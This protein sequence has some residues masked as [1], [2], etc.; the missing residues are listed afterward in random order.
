MKAITFIQNLKQTLLEIETNNSEHIFYVQLDYELVSRV[1]KYAFDKLS[2]IQHETSS[3]EDFIYD[4]M[5]RNIFNSRIRYCIVKLKEFSIDEDEYF[6][7]I[8]QAID[9]FIENRD[10]HFNNSK[11]SIKDRLLMEISNCFH[12]WY[13]P[14]DVFLIQFSQEHQLI[15]VN[16]KQKN[17]QTSN[18]GRFFIELPYFEAISF[19][20]ALEIVLTLE[21]HKNAFLSKKLLGELLRNKS[22]KDGRQRPNTIPYSL[23]LFGVFDRNYNDPEQHKV[24]EFGYQVLSYVDSHLNEFQEII[25]AL[26]ESEVI[27]KCVATS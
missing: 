22:K 3:V 10:Y 15:F 27:G 5:S 17:W 4:L 13:R 11:I 9:F 24:T 25:L 20:S 18:L 12:I 21:V 6:D 8:S 14:D 1:K 16:P 2:K 26:L 7:Y 19:L 23:T